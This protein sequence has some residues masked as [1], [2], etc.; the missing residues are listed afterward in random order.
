M[1]VTEPEF[2]S[3]VSV[4][5]EGNPEGQETGLSETVHKLEG[6]IAEEN[7][8]AAEEVV[9]IL[10]TAVGRNKLW[11]DSYRTS[12]IL[13]YA[14]IGLG[15][16]K[17][18]AKQFLRVIGNTVADNDLNREVAVQHLPAIIDCLQPE[19]SRTTAL[20]VLFNLCNDFDP[21]KAAAATLRLDQTIAGY[22]AGD[23][24]PEAAKDFSTD[25]LTWSTEKLTAVQLKDQESLATFANILKVALQYDEEHYLEYVAVLAHYLQDPDF[26]E[27]VATPEVL[28]NLVGLMLDFEARLTPEEVA[29]VFSELAVSK[30]EDRTANEDTKVILLSQLI[31][32]ISAVSSTDSFAQQF[33][34]R[35][36]VI[37]RVESK[38]RSP[39]DDALPSTVCSCVMLGNLAMSDEVCVD[40]VQIMELHV[41]L[42]DIL[43]RSQS[44]QSAL[45]YAA[46]GFVRHLT[47]PE[48]NR[49]IL[50]EAGLIKACC[51]LLVLADESVRGEAAAILCKLVTKNFRNIEKVVQG[52]VADVADLG[53][54]PASTQSTVLRHIVQQALAPSRPLPSTAMKNPMIELGRTIVAMLRYLGRPNAE[55]DVDALIEEIFKVPMI[56]RPVAKLIRQRFYVD[57]RSE[58]L[59]GLG[60]IAQSS[61]G[62]AQV[63]EEI[64]ADAGLLDAIKEFANGADGGAEQQSPSAGRDYQNAIVLLQALRNNASE[65]MDDALNEQVVALQKELGKL[66]V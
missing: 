2:P 52:S 25:L 39:W 8:N 53:D 57:A 59:L 15:T 56:A 22:L 29:S 17:P 6:L 11:Q 16:T 63:V 3:A 31:G 64:K 4:L 26:Q 66:M 46:A 14:L 13:A 42:I 35:T 37:E 65:E 47:F 49:G 54:A 7:H 38:L 40:M 55:K 36:S 62:A 12:G 28:D 60:L 44:T 9:Q 21:A 1:P 33:S 61:Q 5:L 20:A 41:A 32:S 24:I 45:L 30:D 10:G 18:L 23:D 34:I 43:V 19:A 27:Q 51:R 58:G 50:A 48:Q